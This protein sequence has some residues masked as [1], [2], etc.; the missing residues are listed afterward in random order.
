VI[1]RSRKLADAFRAKNSLVVY[2]RV[3][4]S[5]FLPLAADPATDLP[6]DLP[7]DL[8]EIA[9]CRQAKR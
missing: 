3:L 7:D 9:V 2:V 4:M 8:S 1:E 5:G 6:K